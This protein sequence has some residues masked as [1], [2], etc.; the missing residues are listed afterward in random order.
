VTHVVTAPLIAVVANGERHSLYTGAIIPSGVKSED[1][2]RLTREGYIREVEDTPT[3]P[4]GEGEAPSEPSAIPAKDGPGSGKAR[5]ADYAASL[6]VDVP[7][8][9]GRESIIQAIAEAGHPTE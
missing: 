3:E 1:I 2:E 4:G 5:W 7:E 6:G 8:G 9:A